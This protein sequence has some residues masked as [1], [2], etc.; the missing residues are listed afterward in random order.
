MFGQISIFDKE[1]RFLTQ[2]FITKKIEKFINFIKITFFGDQCLK[3]KRHARYHFRVKKSPG[4]Y[5]P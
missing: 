3:K 1:K 4:R 5:Q 2:I